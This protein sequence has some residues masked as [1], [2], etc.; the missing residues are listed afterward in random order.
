MDLSKRILEID[1]DSPV[2]KSMLQD[3]NKEI[4]RVVEKVYEEEFETGEITL[5]LS[6]S[7]P[8]EFKVYPRKN[9]FGDLVDETYDYRKPYFEH[10]V[11]TNLKKQFKKDGLYTEPKEILFQD[12][13]FIAVPIREPQMNI[14]DK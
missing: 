5:K 7:F 3:L 13:K 12:G 14:F 2:F 11:T 8:K 6:L 10:K 4:L 9:E 1:I